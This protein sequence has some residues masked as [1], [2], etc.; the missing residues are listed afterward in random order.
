MRYELNDYEWSVIK[1]ML[2]NKSRGVPRVDVIADP[3]GA[4]PSTRLGDS[5]FEHDPAKLGSGPLRTIASALRPP[6]RASGSPRPTVGNRRARLTV[7]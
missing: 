2:P 1:P 3:S 5:P 4:R 7:V 6:G